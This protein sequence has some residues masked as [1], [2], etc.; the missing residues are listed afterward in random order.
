LLSTD[1]GT[2]ADPPNHTDA[3]ALSVPDEADAEPPALSTAQ[4]PRV[5]WNRPVNALAF[6]VDHE[7]QPR[8]Y[9]RIDPP[10]VFRNKYAVGCVRVGEVTFASTHT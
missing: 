4:E 2:C 9:M 8:E 3:D 10:A 6:Q 1:A 7:P 5:L